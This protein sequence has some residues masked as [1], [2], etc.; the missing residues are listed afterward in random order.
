MCH[1]QTPVV[2]T[3]NRMDKYFILATLISTLVFIILPLGIIFLIYRLLKRKINLKTARVVSTILLIGLGYFIVR[4]FYPTD[5]FYKSNFEENTNINFPAN[6]KLKAKQGVNNIYNLGDYNISYLIEL[7]N[8]DYQK[9][10]KQLL[11]KNYIIE[12]VYLETNENE[13]LLLLNPELKKETIISKNFG[14]K[15][16]ELLFMNDGKTII[17]NSNKW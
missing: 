13:K 8:Q 1:A 12:M 5:S 16:F 9:L 4:G 15:N 6:A 17:C 10:E 2:P 11:D 3:S 7:S 14:F